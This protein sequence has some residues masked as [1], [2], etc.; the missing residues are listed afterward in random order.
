[1]SLSCPE[2]TRPSRTQDAELIEHFCVDTDGRKHGPWLQLSIDGVK[3]RSGHFEHGEQSGLW[4]VYDEGG[5]L[6]LQ[7]ELVGGKRQGVWTYYH[8]NGSKRSESTYV[9]GIREGAFV[10]WY[11]D[12]F[13]MAEGAYRNDL[14]DGEWKIYGLRG[15]LEKTCLMDAG[16]QVSCTVVE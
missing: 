13:L 5:A 4:S 6:H 14:E 3:R 1:M 11:A 15:K 16:K 2:Q 8:L 7:G 9:A 10:S 12:G